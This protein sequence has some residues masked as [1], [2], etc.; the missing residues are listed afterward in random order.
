VSSVLVLG[1]WIV[2]V[3]IISGAI[4]MNFVAVRKH[5]NFEKMEIFI[6]WVFAK[7]ERNGLLLVL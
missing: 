5:Q 2:I 7:K 3:D 1:Y 4:Q 6:S